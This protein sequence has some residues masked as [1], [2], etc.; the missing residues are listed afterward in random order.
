[1]DDAALLDALKQ[2]DSSVLAAL[3][4]RYADALYRLAVRLLG[5]EQQADGVVQTAFLA[6]LD[7]ADRFEGRANIGTWL[8]RVAYNECLM[9]LR[10]APPVS[11]DDLAGESGE[12]MPSC[13]VDW[14]NLP[15]EALLN[16]EAH[17]EM[18][19]AINSLTP[20]LRA[21]FTLR[22]VEELSV[23]ETAHILNLSEAAVKTNL[24]RARLHLRER[25]SRY[26]ERRHT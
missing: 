17:A 12:F 25:L 23:S 18:E 2:R 24:H 16:E 14:R 21:V 6:L 5:D 26:F 8:Y 15:E 11:L 7:H 9:R 3:F 10:A 20:T 1:V 19:R 22:D 13:L 4:T